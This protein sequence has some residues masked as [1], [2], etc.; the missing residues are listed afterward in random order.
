MAGANLD[1]CCFLEMGHDA[2][3]AQG[4]SRAVAG[5]GQVSCQYLATV[6]DFSLNAS[7]IGRLSNKSWTHQAHGYGQAVRINARMDRSLPKS[8]GTVENTLYRDNAMQYG[9]VYICNNDMC[10]LLQES[11]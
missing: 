11:S 8:R 9:M 4:F 2:R 5:R 1:R 7:F 6:R 10:S 3:R